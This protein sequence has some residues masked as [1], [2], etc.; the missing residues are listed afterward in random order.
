MCRQGRT[1]CLHMLSLALFAYAMVFLECAHEL[2]NSLF[3][4]YAQVVLLLVE[5]LLLLLLLL[6]LLILLL[7]LI[8]LLPCVDFGM[9]SSFQ[10]SSSSP[11]VD[12]GPF[13]AFQATPGSSRLRRREKS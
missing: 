5:V 2:T 6:L 8:L 11:G 3:G 7:I 1:H 12:F 13:Y 9:F 4:V 10:A